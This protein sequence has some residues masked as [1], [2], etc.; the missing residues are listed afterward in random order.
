MQFKKKANNVKTDIFL[1]NLFIIL[2]LNPFLLIILLY[3]I[4]SI[5]VCK[6]FDLIFIIFFKILFFYI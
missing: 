5:L 6:F 2:N 3:S 1:N 4:K